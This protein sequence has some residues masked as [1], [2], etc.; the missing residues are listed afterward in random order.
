[1]EYGFINNI[2]PLWNHVKIPYGIQIYVSGSKDSGHPLASG[3]WWYP[4]KSPLDY[5]EK[6]HEIPTQSHEIPTKSHEI[7]TQ[8]HEIPTKSH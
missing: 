8:S 1:M 5:H 3:G 4:M 6:S 2:H 7:P